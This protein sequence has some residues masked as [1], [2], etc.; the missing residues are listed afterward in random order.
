[1]IKITKKGDNFVIT[2]EHKNH[3][4]KASIIVT[5]KELIILHFGINEIITKAIDEE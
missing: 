1:M 3:V 4:H 5:G 2:V